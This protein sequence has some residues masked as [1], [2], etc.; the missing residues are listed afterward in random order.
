MKKYICKI[1][2]FLILCFLFLACPSPFERHHVG[3]ITVSPTVANGRIQ[4]RSADVEVGDVV[5]LSVFP[6]AGYKL[7]EGSL[8]Y[9]FDGRQVAIPASGFKMPAGDV[10]IHAEFVS[11]Y[12]NTIS[13]DRQSTV[14]IGE[15]TLTG[16]A[17]SESPNFSE[18]IIWDV[19][20]MGIVSITEQ[21][22]V[23]SRDSFS[24]VVTVTQTITVKAL[25][26]SG[27]LAITAKTTELPDGASCFV[28]V[29]AGGIFDKESYGSDEIRITG[30]IAGRSIPGTSFYIPDIMDNKM[31]VAVKENAFASYDKKITSIYISSSVREIG[32]NSFTGSGFDEVEKIDVYAKSPPVIDNSKDIFNTINLSNIFVSA[33]SSKDYRVLWSRYEKYIIGFGQYRITLA[34]AEGGTVFIDE[35][36][37][38]PGDIVALLV[39]PDPGKDLDLV[40]GIAVTFKPSPSSAETTEYYYAP[41]FPMPMSNV[42]VTV[43]FKMKAAGITVDPA[44]YFTLPHALEQPTRLKTKSGEVRVADFKYYYKS[45]SEDM[46]YV[47]IYNKFEENGTT[48]IKA[49]YCIENIDDFK[50]FD[51]TTNIEYTPTD[52]SRVER[53]DAELAGTDIY[54]RYKFK[55]PRTALLTLKIKWEILKTTVSVHESK[56]AVRGRIVPVV[57]SEATPLAT[58]EVLYGY[59]GVMHFPYESRN[60]ELYDSSDAPILKATDPKY[61]KYLKGRFNNPPYR[62][63][64]IGFEIPLDKTSAYSKTEKSIFEYKKYVSSPLLSSQNVAMSHVDRPFGSELDEQGGIKTFEVSEPWNVDE[65]HVKMYIAWEGQLLSLALE[66]TPALKP[67]TITS[68][69]IKY[70]TLIEDTDW[71]TLGGPFFPKEVDYIKGYKFLGAFVADIADLKNNYTEDGSRP[72]PGLQII[73]ES[74]SFIGKTWGPSFY[75]AKDADTIPASMPFTSHPLQ[76]VPPSDPYDTS[77]PAACQPYK[78]SKT[79]SVYGWWQD[80]VY[81]V[82]LGDEWQED[83]NAYRDEKYAPLWNEKE[84]YYE[85]WRPSHLIHLSLRPKLWTSKF[86]QMKDLRMNK[87]GGSL[88]FKP[89]G[90]SSAFMGEYDGGGF[91]IHNLCIEETTIAGVGL[92]SRISAGARVKNLTIESGRIE[93]RYAGTEGNRGV[94]GIV[95]I[96]EAG[97]VV[98]NVI[99]KAFI[100]SSVSNTGGVVGIYRLNGSA[101]ISRLGNGF[102][103]ENKGSNLNPPASINISGNYS[104]VGGVI[105]KIEAP[106]NG[107][108]TVDSI[109]NHGNIMSSFSDSLKRANVGGLIGFIE[110]NGGAFELIRS[111]NAGKVEVPSGKNVASLIAT[112]R[113]LDPILEKYVGL[114]SVKLTSVYSR[115]PSI[116][117]YDD[118]AIAIAG[119]QNATYVLKNS[120]LVATIKATASGGSVSIGGDIPQGADGKISGVDFEGRVFVSTHENITSLSSRADLWFTSYDKD[121]PYGQTGEVSAPVGS[122]VGRTYIDSKDMITHLHDPSPKPFDDI[123]WSHRS[124]LLA[125]IGSISIINLWVLKD[126]GYDSDANWDG[127][128]VK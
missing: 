36:C 84:G 78:V 13:V 94:G 117:G 87:T 119:I 61:A 24:G 72:P 75:I 4:F 126:V 118:V 7:K 17:V 81:G 29:L 64:C 33:A 109:F 120:F 65:K 20:E 128:E 8:H 74:R 112:V 79:S 114:D 85:I 43:S 25:R 46:L 48:Y 39:N 10:V 41:Y 91:K 35:D 40:K 53:G 121:F 32:A 15:M 2:F 11:E 26:D 96:V 82:A 62:K 51:T 106:D 116:I 37:A 115:S 50:I 44:S 102:G 12:L 28:K 124:A 27:E 54:Y 22:P 97:G 88:L 3:T 47:D 16:T 60:I 1:V 113:I 103:T 52:F 58:F 31:V 45:D 83:Q 69:M 111:Y 73:D 38:T 100:H 19:S 56:K 122:L 107:T 30:I 89:I 57:D 55:K 67:G 66:M 5:A 6:N 110:S 99:N 105:G 68:N 18:E 71:L 98:E 80:Y 123:N 77:Y 92:F 63:E 59:S 101:S 76:P 125:P 21:D 23:V 9:I 90:A 42:F 95:G 93:S 127:W 108:I 34:E 70:D 86:K 14:F 104:N 49:G